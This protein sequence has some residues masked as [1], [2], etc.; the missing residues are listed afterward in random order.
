[1]SEQPSLCFFTPELDLDTP[2]DPWYNRAVEWIAL[3]RDAWD[4]MVARARAL[5]AVG[6]FV[7]MKALIEWARC[8]IPIV[9]PEREQ[10]AI[11]NSMSPAMGRIMVAEHPELEGVIKTRRASCD[12]I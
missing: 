12:E 1:M 6:A 7:G 4:A 8:E 5:H 9:R 11:N 3:N 2:N 10:F